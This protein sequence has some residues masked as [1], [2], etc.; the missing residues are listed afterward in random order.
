MGMNEKNI[1][2]D[3][4]LQ[5]VTGGAGGAAFDA[6]RKEFDDAWDALGMEQK[7]FSGMSRSEYFDEWQMSGSKMSAISF[8]SYKIR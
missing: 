4:V 8:L 2:G 3:D 6:K 1:L 5:G 7:G